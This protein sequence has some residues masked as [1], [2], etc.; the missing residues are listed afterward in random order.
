MDHFFEDLQSGRFELLKTQG[1]DEVLVV[2]KKE[3]LALS[4]MDTQPVPSL[5]S[6]SQKMDNFQ[7]IS[8]LAM[9]LYGILNSV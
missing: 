3:I 4:T 5:D 7:C 8:E 9:R 2:A 6:L 1:N